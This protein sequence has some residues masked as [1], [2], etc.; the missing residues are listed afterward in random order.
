MTGFG[1]RFVNSSSSSSSSLLLLLRASTTFL[2]LHPKWNR[3]AACGSRDRVRLC[4]FRCYHEWPAGGERQ[5]TRAIF[6]FVCIASESIA[7]RDGSYDGAHNNGNL[8]MEIQLLNKIISTMS[9][10]CCYITLRTGI[11]CLLL[12]STFANTT[13][14]LS[15]GLNLNRISCNDSFSSG[16]SSK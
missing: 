12:S 7:G 6:C 10:G 8:A 3:F 16:T 1:L 4:S 11:R 5:G 15:T 2:L 14:S 13:L 9:L